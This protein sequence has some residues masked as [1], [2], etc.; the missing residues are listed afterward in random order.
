[1]TFL[2]SPGEGIEQFFI[3]LL[4]GVSLLCVVVGYLSYLLGYEYGLRESKKNH[5]RGFPVIPVKPP[6]SLHK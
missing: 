3:C 1:M 2:A 6:E 4:F 5:R